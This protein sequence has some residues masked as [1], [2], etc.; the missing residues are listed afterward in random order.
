MEYPKRAV[1]NDCSWSNRVS[2]L[3]YG[4]LSCCFPPNDSVLLENVEIKK[5]IITTIFFLT[6]FQVFVFGVGNFVDC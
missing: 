3:L 1:W 2:E 6:S 5:L 4:C